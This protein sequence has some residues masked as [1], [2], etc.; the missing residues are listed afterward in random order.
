MNRLPAR[1]CLAYP[2]TV[3]SAGDRVRLVAGEDFR[4][5][6]SGPGLGDWL[7]GWLPLLD[8][9]RT[10]GEALAAL[11]EP[12]RAAARQVV[13]R[14]CGE[15]VLVDGPTEAAHAPRRY[16]VAPEGR[17]I[18]REALEATAA[19]EA[20]EAVALPVLC[21]DS[22]DYDEALRF[23]RRC[24]DGEVPW[25]WLTCGP[26]GRGYVSPAFLPNAGPC[27]A[28]LLGHFRRLS[29]LPELYDELAEHARRGGALA[30]APFPPHA[31]AVLA[32]TLRWKAELLGRAEPPSAPYRLHVL[33]VATLELTAHPV[34]RAPE[35][36]ACAGRR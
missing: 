32:H 15:R 27:L 31:A 29:P 8:G 12:Q 11:P 10:L 16:R 7:P 33:E 14:L 1:P 21:Q 26:L 9:S 3:L 35:C 34:F 24:L 4:Y 18:L 19:E 6:L 5:T 25:L 30:A 36:E 23:N 2:F 22:L 17:G 20:P 13:E 28:C